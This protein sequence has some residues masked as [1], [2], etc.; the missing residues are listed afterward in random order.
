[1]FTRSYLIAYLKRSEEFVLRFFFFFI[2]NI[3]HRIKFQTN[4][5]EVV[6]LMNALW[7]SLWEECMHWILCIL[8]VFF[9]KMHGIGYKKVCEATYTTGPTPPIKTKTCEL[10]CR[11]TMQDC[12]GCPVHTPGGNWF[13]VGCQKHQCTNWLDFSELFWQ[14]IGLWGKKKKKNLNSDTK[15][16]HPVKALYESAVWISH[17]RL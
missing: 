11:P 1:M 6:V 9:E 2:L 10:W 8:C 5:V 16:S 13:Y 14:L 4:V 3:G 17:F 7:T 12:M 15:P